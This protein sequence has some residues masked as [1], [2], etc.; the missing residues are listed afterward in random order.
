[1]GGKTLDNPLGP[2]LWVGF[3]ST[4]EE[5]LNACIPKLISC[6]R[7]MLN[8]FLFLLTGHVSP[9][10][11]IFLTRPSQIFRFL[12]KKRSA[13]FLFFQTSNL[14][15]IQRPNHSKAGRNNEYLAFVRFS[16]ILHN[17]GLIKYIHHQTRGTYPAHSLNNNA[18]F[19]Q[20]S[21]GMVIQRNSSTT[22]GD[23]NRK[24]TPYL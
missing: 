21:F 23:K 16:S 18:L 17:R 4:I 10:F 22:I 24:L 14:L 5:K 9:L 2:I 15:G 6:S 3:S 11:C 13:D 7:N 1:M 20:H 19:V 12:M 8:I